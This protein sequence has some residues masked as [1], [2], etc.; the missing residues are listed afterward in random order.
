[1]V[2]VIGLAD[3]QGLWRRLSIVTPDFEDRETVVYW[4]QAN[5][6]HVDLRVPPGLHA[7]PDPAVH[8]ACEGFAGTTEVDDGVCT[9]T[10]A[11]NLQGPVAGPDVGRLHWRGSHLIETGVHAEYEEVWERVASGG[12]SSHVE[13]DGPFLTVETR[14]GDHRAHGRG[15]PADL[16]LARTL[17]ERVRAGDTAALDR[18]T[19]ELFRGDERIATTSP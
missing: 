16:G 15:R 1:M 14:C 7:P 10:R 18:Q 2:H 11:I 4:C 6:H 3:V 19:F 9:W 17:A 13:R 5:E 12:V 8:A